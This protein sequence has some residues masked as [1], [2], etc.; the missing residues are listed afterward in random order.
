MAEEE[1]K[2]QNSEESK[3]PK[4]QDLRNNNIFEKNNEDK[5]F[6]KLNRLAQMLPIEKNWMIREC[7]AYWDEWRACIS[8]KGR[9]YQKYSKCYLTC[10]V[11]KL[12]I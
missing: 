8:I 11:R 12:G 5:P 7:N 4:S 2:T 1:S 9:L 10:S 6:Y 3:S